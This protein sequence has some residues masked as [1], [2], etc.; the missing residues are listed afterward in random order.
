MSGRSPKASEPL[1]LVGLPPRAQAVRFALQFKIWDLPDHLQKSLD[2]GHP[3]IARAFFEKMDLQRFNHKDNLIRR[4]ITNGFDFFILI[5]CCP[6][7]WPWGEST[8]RLPLW[9]WKVLHRN[10]ELNS[11]LAR[12][13]FAPLKPNLFEFCALRRFTDQYRWRKEESM[14]PA[15]IDRRNMREICV[16]NAEWLRNV[17][18]PALLGP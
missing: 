2:E 1:S 5:D 18:P 6:H 4:S 11:R 15:Y 16:A 10:G 14:G 12:R 9:S 3:V 13:D 7:D 8:Y 17:A